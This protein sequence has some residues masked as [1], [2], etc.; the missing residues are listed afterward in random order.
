[1]PLC[2]AASPGDVWTA[3]VEFEQSIAVAA[4]GGRVLRNFFPVEAWNNSD[5][6]PWPGG[7]D[8]KAAALL[9]VGVDTHYMHGGVCNDRNCDCSTPDVLDIYA[10]DPKISVLVTDDIVTGNA[11]IADTTGIA[12]VSTGDESDGEIYDD[13]GV[14]EAAKKAARARE[15][16]ALHPELPVFNGGKTNG[17]V[18]TFAGMTDI[19]GM[20]V[21]IG[22]CAPHITAW[23][24]H[25][26]V[27]MPFDYLRNTRDN[28]MPLPTWLYAQG[29]SPVGAWKAQPSP[30]EI[31]AQGVMVIAASGKGL[32]WFQANQEKGRS[33]A[34]KLAG[35]GRRQPYHSGRARLAPR[36]RSCRLRDEHRQ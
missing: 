36:W 28:H 24:T 35:D 11:P 16:W 22:G 23:G 2:E 1:M 27:R 32:M 7:N 21:Y 14:P 3:A 5:E 15:S 19:Q 31:I 10:R 4:G 6:C 8:E 9:A 30:S 13:Q 29:L 33:L 34:G 26:P 18:G 17:H 20:D 25:P 12:A